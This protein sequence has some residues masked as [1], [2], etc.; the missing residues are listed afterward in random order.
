MHTDVLQNIYGHAKITLLSDNMVLNGKNLQ[1]ISL[2]LVAGAITGIMLTPFVHPDIIINSFATEPKLWFCFLMSVLIMAIGWCLFTCAETTI[3]INIPDILLLA[4]LLNMVFRKFF[5]SIPFFDDKFII[6]ICVVVLYFAFKFIIHFADTR[7]IRKLTN[8]ATVFVFVILLLSCCYGVLQLTDVI[9]SNSPFFK[10]TGHFENPAW[11]ANYLISLVPFCIVVYSYHPVRPN[12]RW[13][14]KYSAFII[15]FIAVLVLFTTYA[16]AAWI[17]LFV[18]TIFIIWSLYRQKLTTRLHKLLIVGMLCF[19]SIGAGFFLFKFKPQSSLGR[20]TIWKISCNIIADHPFTGVGYGNFEYLYDRYQASYFANNVATGQELE[21]ADITRYPYNIFL[22]ILCEQGLIGFILFC[23]F[24]YFLIKGTLNKNTIND[25]SIFWSVAALASMIAIITCGMFSYPF[26][27][28]PVSFFFYIYGGI[29]SG[30]MRG[31]KQVL[32]KIDQRF[33]KILGLFFLLSAGFLF[34]ITNSKFSANKKWKE[35]S[36][37]YSDEVHLS[38]IYP[39]LEADVFFM[40]YYSREL[41]Y[42]KKYK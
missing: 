14:L 10:L 23:S 11:Y 8:A 38:K 17:G 18:S 40:E 22:Q 24:L 42:E 27:I 1:L 13:Y 41:L 19:I 21:L 7:Q 39:V 28:I 25:Y 29:L 15:V 2:H 9:S 33:L 12:F 32:L 35:I 3:N 26:D 30:Y 31:Q 36:M 4:G 16:R 34:A 6:Y 37:L 5:L 20:L